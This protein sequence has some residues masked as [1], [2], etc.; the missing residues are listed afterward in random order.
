M[1]G[2]RVQEAPNVTSYPSYDGK[3]VINVLFSSF[4]DPDGNYVELNEILNSGPR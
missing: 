4:Y 3:G 2:V 1:P